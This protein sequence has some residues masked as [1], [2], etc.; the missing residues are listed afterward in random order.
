MLR[1][2][3]AQGGPGGTRAERGSVRRGRATRLRASCGGGGQR[4][5][6]GLMGGRSGPP[7]RFGPRA[8]CGGTGQRAEG[9]L[10]GGRSGPPLR[11]G[12]H[13]VAASRL[14]QN[15]GEMGRL[16]GRATSP[17]LSSESASSVFSGPCFFGRSTQRT[18]PGATSAAP[19]PSCRLSPKNCDTF[20]CFGA[21]WV[22]RGLFPLRFNPPENVHVRHGLLASL[23]GCFCSLVPDR[24]EVERPGGSP[25]GT[26]LIMHGPSDQHPLSTGFTSQIEPHRRR[27]GCVYSPLAK[28]HDRGR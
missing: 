15:G 16:P 17:R 8:S 27:R 9:G 21:G 20:N 13:P 2:V 6:G 7:L 24:Q 5:E 23:V 4:A 11:S 14:G 28:A 3:G 1:R 12:W 22:R 10:M 19:T 26:R 18:M 25:A